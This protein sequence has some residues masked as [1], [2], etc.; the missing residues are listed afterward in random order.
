MDQSSKFMHRAQG[1]KL[2]ILTS[3][4][5]NFSASILT[6]EGL[7]EVV[8]HREQFGGWR[9]ISG[10]MGK[11]TPFGYSLHNSLNQQ[12]GGIMNYFGK[13]QCPAPDNPPNQIVNKNNKQP[14][15]Q[16]CNQSSNVS[17][18]PTDSQSIHLLTS[19][20]ISLPTKQPTTK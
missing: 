11:I 9:D 12:Y 19:A 13:F 18:K 17:N 6:Q 15:N 20:S 7:H 16:P 10:I 5:Y 8:S 4:H 1:M 2:E 3:Q 14:T